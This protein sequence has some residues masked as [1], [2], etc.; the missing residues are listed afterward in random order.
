VD[1]LEHAVPPDGCEIVG[2]EHGGVGRD[3]STTE[4]GYDSH[5]F[6]SLATRTTI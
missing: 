4:D 1:R 6:S 5:K 2:T 3:D